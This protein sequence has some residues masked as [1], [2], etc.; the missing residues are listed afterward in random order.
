MRTRQKR[1]LT[2]TWRSLGCRTKGC[3]KAKFN[4]DSDHKVKRCTCKRPNCRL[5]THL[6]EGT[7]FE[8]NCSRNFYVHE[9]MTC[10]V[11]KCDLRHEMQ[12][13]RQ[14]V[15]RRNRKLLTKKR[16]T[17]HNQQIRDPS[18]RMLHV[19][20]HISTCTNRQDPKY[21]I[22]PFYKMYSESTSL[23]RAK[24]K[25]FMNLLKPKLNRFS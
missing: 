13:L 4:N 19:S 6:F 7:A 22:F 20:E 21:N 15:Y 11:K 24:E 25:Y 9:S 16:V 1:V 12:R 3:R 23:R 5:C 10:E 2:D 8:F 18:I 14:R 17:V